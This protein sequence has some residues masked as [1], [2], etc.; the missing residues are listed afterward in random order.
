MPVGPYRLC[1]NEAELQQSH[2]LAAG[3]YRLARSPGDRNA[4]PVLTVPGHAMKSSRQVRTWCFAQPVKSDS[5]SAAKTG[6]LANCLRSMS[7]FPLQDVLLRTTP[8][9]VAPT[10]NFAIFGTAAI[11]DIDPAQLAFFAASVF[12]RAGGACLANRKDSD[13]ASLA[14]A[15]RRGT[16]SLFA[17]PRTVSSRPVARGWGGPATPSR[18]LDCIPVAHGHN[19][20]FRTYWFK[21]PGLSFSLLVGRGLNRGHR[22]LCLVRS[23]LRNIYVADILDDMKHDFIMRLIS[24]AQVHRNVRR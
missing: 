8:L 4:D 11:P 17:R 22:D 6:Y 20:T 21:V 3:F 7:E 14:R 5:I 15:L 12:W 19:A 1:L 18:E 23:P 24:S 10:V 2:L 13:A 9:Y 16:A